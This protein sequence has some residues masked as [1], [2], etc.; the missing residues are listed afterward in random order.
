[1]MMLD[2]IQPSSGYL[3]DNRQSG[4]V[5]GVAFL[6]LLLLLLPIVPMCC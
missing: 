5:T 3:L 4:P 2:I 1:M 6:L